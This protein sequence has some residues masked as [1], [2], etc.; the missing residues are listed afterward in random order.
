MSKRGYWL[1]SIAVVALLAG[2]A[3]PAHAVK[4]LNYAMGAVCQP[5][6]LISVVSPLTYTNSGFLVE[7]LSSVDVVCP[8]TWAKPT[9]PAGLIVG[10]V[11]IEVDWLLPFGVPAPINA[12]SLSYQSLGGSLSMQAL[13]IPYP[14]PANMVNMAYGAIVCTVP[15]W[16]GIQGVSFN[17]CVTTATNP[18]ACPAPPP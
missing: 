3:R 16:V 4:S 10:E 9:V 14:V 5:A 15:P 6:S 18:G 11:D 17:M 7:G 8:I 1:C 13:P 2:L 12:C